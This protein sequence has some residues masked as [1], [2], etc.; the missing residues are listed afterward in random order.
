MVVILCYLY[1][2][3]SFVSNSELINLNFDL[4]DNFILSF[5]SFIQTGFNKY[6]FNHGV[7]S[8]DPTYLDSIIV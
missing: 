2:F 7:A 6:T 3:K 5:N 8:G 4:L 1:Y